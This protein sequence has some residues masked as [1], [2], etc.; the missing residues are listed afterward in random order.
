MSLL[1]N[2][3]GRLWIRGKISVKWKHF[4]TFFINCLYIS[5]LIYYWH[6]Q[7]INIYM[8]C[9]SI[10]LALFI[11]QLKILIKV[12]SW[13]VYNDHKKWIY[14]VYLVYT[15]GLFYNQWFEDRSDCSFCW[16]WWNYY[17]IKHC[18]LGNYLC[19]NS[20]SSLTNWIKSEGL[21]VKFVSEL[22]W[23]YTYIISYKHSV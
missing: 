16:Y 12:D 23:V 3:I 5:L 4:F 8:K 9:F 1:K 17:R 7:P 6:P 20:S 18:F 14:N 15:C 19:I 11:Y 21:Y 13:N 22:S 2:G 10:S